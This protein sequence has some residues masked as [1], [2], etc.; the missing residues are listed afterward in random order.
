MGNAGGLNAISFFLHTVSPRVAIVTPTNVK[1]TR[2]MQTKYVFLFNDLLPRFFIEA[3][4]ES[5]G[6]SSS[7]CL[8]NPPLI[9]LNVQRSAVETIST[10][11]FRWV[12]L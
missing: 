10:D 7:Y 12:L 8:Y 6:C 3:T 11:Y 1:T 9:D 5:S 4:L 2:P